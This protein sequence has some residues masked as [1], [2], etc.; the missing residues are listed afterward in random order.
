MDKEGAI[1]Y[2]VQKIKALREG[3]DTLRSHTL[4]EHN[5]VDIGKHSWG[6]AILIYILHPSPSK[7]L[8]IEALLHDVPE[9]WAGDPPAPICWGVGRKMK[10]EYRKITQIIRE[11]LGIIQPAGCLSATDMWWLKSCDM[12]DFWLWCNEQIM[13]GNDNAVG[14]RR[15]ARNFFG[16]NYQTI[17]DIIFHVLE[18]YRPG[19]TDDEIGFVLKIG[20]DEGPGAIR[21]RIKN[22][23][24][25]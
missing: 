19:R 5:R 8:L 24:G 14:P 2:K 21:E 12:L 6:V 1:N 3:G 15:N 18:N 22:K 25:D 4:G 17:P 10:N 7:E 11:E 16:E 23:I 20:K 13:L 9:R